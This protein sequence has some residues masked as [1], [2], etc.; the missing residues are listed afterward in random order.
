MVQF[1]PVLAVMVGVAP[2]L[3][4]LEAEAGRPVP[5][6]VPGLALVDT[7]CTRTAIDETV[8]AKLGV[9]PTGVT[10]VGTAGGQRQS[11]LCAVQLF[12]PTLGNA[13]IVLPQAMSCDLSGQGPLVLLGRDLLQYFVM[14]YDGPT[15]RVVLMT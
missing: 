8:I 6:P 5:T 1:G 9:A 14:I 10:Q 3:A 2:A 15:G 13:D 11:V 7:G 4:K 12:F